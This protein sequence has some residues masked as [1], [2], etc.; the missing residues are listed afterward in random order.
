[1]LPPVSTAPFLYRASMQAARAVAPLL[2]AGGSKLARGIS[3]RR[4]AH[5]ALA[6]WGKTER[7]PARPTAW[8]HAP[9][10]GEALQAGAVMQALAERR[11][12]LQHVFTHFSPSA[13]GIGARV[14]AHVAA[15]LPWDVRD[16]V[17]AALDGAR[18]ALL[19]FTKTEVWPVLVEGAVQRRIPAVMIAATVPENAGRL[20]WPARDLLRS[21]WGSLALA[22]ACSDVDAAGLVT[23]GVPAAHVHVT[24]DPG[25]DA[26]AAR[27]ARVDP[28]SATLAPFHAAR[29]RTVVAGSTWPEDEAELLPALEEARRKVPDVR[30]I[31]APHEPSTERVAA[32]LAQLRRTGWK[33]STLAEVEARTS[34]SDLDA[35][36]V[37]RVGVLA[38]LYTVA[39]VAFVGGGFGRRGLH[40]V[41]EP[42]AARVPVVF[43]P[44]HGRSSAAGALLASGGARSASNGRGLAEAISTWLLDPDARG[45]AAEHAFIYIDRHRG[46]AGR[47]AELLAPL[48]PTPTTE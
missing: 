41:L 3:G 6:R 7:D 40:S 30:V 17:G 44:H 43:G 24:G 8:F 16:A 18:P 33:S 42:A 31:V 32:L 35:M 38:E 27:A 15:Y 34:A 39:D 2:G 22:C 25:V 28:K 48:V 45:R 4:Y 1:M 37:E 11:P 20:R 14:G 36:I 13:E 47:T 12:G 23:L 26:A 21:T 5:E 10:V 46:A 19:A 9:S 29:R